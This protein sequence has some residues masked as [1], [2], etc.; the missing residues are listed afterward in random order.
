M[1]ASKHVADHCSEATMVDL[2]IHIHHH[3]RKPESYAAVT[4]LF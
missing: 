1:E 2:S 4:A 3:L